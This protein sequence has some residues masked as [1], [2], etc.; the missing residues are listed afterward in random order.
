MATLYARTFNLKDS[1]SDE[2]VLEFWRLYME[3][4][5]PAAQ[6]ISGTRS[7]KAYSGAGGLRADITLLWEMDDASVYE[8]ALADPNIGKLLG[9]YYGA[10]DL[11]SATQSFR[12][13][14]TAELIQ[15]IGGKG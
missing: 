6:N 9:K 11:K 2:E 5:A 4:I 1:L 7:V 12:R 3:E 15:A 14:V 10:W 13:E 8:R